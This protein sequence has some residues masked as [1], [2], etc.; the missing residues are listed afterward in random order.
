MDWRVRMRRDGLELKRL[1]CSLAELRGDDP[2]IRAR[3]DGALRMLSDK[4]TQM[5]GFIEDC[6]CGRNASEQSMMEYRVRVEFP[7]Y[8]HLGSLSVIAPDY[9]DWTCA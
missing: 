3:R 1:V 4:I 9:V 2:R 8:S 6:L 5:R 7:L